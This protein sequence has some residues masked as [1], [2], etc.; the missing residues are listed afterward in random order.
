MTSKSPLTFVPSPAE[1]RAQRERGTSVG[2]WIVFA[3]VVGAY[4]AVLAWALMTPA[5]GAR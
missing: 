1:L 5:V 4:V 3:V 2:D